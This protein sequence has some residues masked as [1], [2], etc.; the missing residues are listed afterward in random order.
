MTRTRQHD[1]DA[2]PGPTGAVPPQDAVIF[3][4]DGVVI[5]TATVHA[6]A[7]KRLFDAVLVD[8]RAGP[9]APFDVGSDYRR[10]VDGRSREDGVA[11]FLAARGIRVP[12]GVASDPAGSWT[13]HGLATRKNAI[14]RELL[15]EHGVRVFSGTVELVRRLRDGGVPVA[16]VTA[17]RN[18]GSLLASADLVGVFDVVVD[19]EL[20]LAG[21]PDPAMFRPWSCEATVGSSQG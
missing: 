9:Q 2:V 21:K 13:V 12:L 7:W 19:G 4:M 5:D 8:D 18:A 10:Y 20:E 17:S 15:A 11:A 6:A 3:D 14:Y 1:P 16:L